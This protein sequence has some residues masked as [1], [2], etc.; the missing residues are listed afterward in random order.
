MQYPD[1][2]TSAPPATPGFRLAVT[3]AVVPVDDAATP[4]NLPDTIPRPG[5]CDPEVT[6]A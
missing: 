2:V 1:I 6:I 5:S 4:E 3:V